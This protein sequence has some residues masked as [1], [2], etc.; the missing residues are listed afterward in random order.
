MFYKKDSH[1]EFAGHNIREFDI[2]YICRRMIANHLALP[3]YLQLN[4]LKPWEVKAVDT[5]HW[6]RFGDYK[7]YISLNLLAHVLGVPSSK[8]DISGADVHRVYYEENNLPRIATYCGKDVAVAANIVLRLNGFP[9]IA[10]ENIL[11]T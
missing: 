8:D 6:W 9:M 11:F 4:N 10:E 7:N 3:P 5:L 2:P 1:F